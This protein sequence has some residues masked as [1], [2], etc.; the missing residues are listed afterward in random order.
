MQGDE[1]WTATL[2]PRACPTSSARVRTTISSSVFSSVSVRRRLT[3]LERST[4]E[5]P[6]AS[7]AEAGE[8]RRLSSCVLRAER[9]ATWSLRCARTGRSERGTWTVSEELP[10][11]RE[12]GAA[13]CCWA[14]A[15][16]GRARGLRVRTSS[17]ACGEESRR[18]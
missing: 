18:D 5:R 7:A 12:A 8:S 16:G 2:N 3:T 11:R 13:G 17:V 10:S 15:G 1:P 4:G 6:G 14:S 9:D